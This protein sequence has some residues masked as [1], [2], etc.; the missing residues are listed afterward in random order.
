VTLDHILYPIFKTSH[1]IFS[2]NLVDTYLTNQF[3]NRFIWYATDIEHHI[4]NSGAYNNKLI[5]FGF[6]A[7]VEL[8]FSKIPRHLPLFVM[9]RETAGKN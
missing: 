1:F 3:K 4:E 5:I 9:L 7:N 8:M 2:S 6:C